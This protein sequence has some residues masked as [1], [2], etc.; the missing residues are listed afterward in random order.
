MNLQSELFHDSN[1]LAWES[2]NLFSRGQ[3]FPY[4]WYIIQSILKIYRFHFGIHEIETQAQYDVVF[5]LKAESVSLDILENI[6]NVFNVDNNIVTN[7][8][9]G[10]VDELYTYNNQ[11]KCVVS[12]KRKLHRK[13]ATRV[14]LSD[15]RFHLLS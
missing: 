15:K 2:F 5:T 3:S 9:I 6:N 8:K 14:V 13:R 11:V 1:I 4:L 12:F 7:H 10:V